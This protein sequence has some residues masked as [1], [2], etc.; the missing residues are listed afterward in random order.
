MTETITKT[1]KVRKLIA[2]RGF[3]FIQPDATPDNS[4]AAVFFHRTSCEAFDRLLEND[5]VTYTEEASPK[6]P[7]ASSVS[8]V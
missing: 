2:E 3:G 7:R 4:Q 6:G 8:P 5:P 1:G